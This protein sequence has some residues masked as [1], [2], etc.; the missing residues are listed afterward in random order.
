MKEKILIFDSTLRDGAQGEGISFSVRDKIAVCRALS[1]LGVD[2]I[3][4]GNPASNPK[5]AEFFREIVGED[6]GKTRL[7]A[8][9]STRRKGVRAEDDEGLRALLE[10]NTPVVAV[11]G[12]SWD[13][14][15]TEIIRVGLGENLNMIADTVKYLKD[16]GKQVVF[17]AEH[18]FDGYKHNPDYAI[19]SLVAAAD[20]GADYIAL[21]DTNGGCFPSEIAEMTRAAIA[22][23]DVP[24]MIHAHDDGGMAVANSVT[25]VES[26]ARGVQGTL[27]GFGERCGNANLATIIANLQLKRGYECLTAEKM[28]ELTGTSRKIAEIA[29]VRLPGNAPY[30]GKSAFAHK[31]GMHAD[32]VSKSSVSFEHV[33]PEAVGNSRRFLTSE[34]AGRGAILEK[35]RKIDASV[36]KDNP[37]TAD[38][39]NKIKEMEY[40]GY[41]FEGAEASFEL[42]VLKLLGAYK[43][44]FAL[45]KFK[46]IG[47]QATGK[48][49][50]PATAVVKVRVGDETEIRAAEGNGPVNA[51]DVALRA[52]LE[53]F[54][55]ELGGFSLTDYKVRIIDSRETSSAKTRVLIE[56][57][58]GRDVW[59]TVG[60][61]RDIIEAS[62]IALRDAIEYKLAKDRGVIAP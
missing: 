29:N 61:S 48:D 8:F 59:T 38:I 40:L 58:D 60:V 46:T 6:F 36:T 35:V 50:S 7:T 18:F 24:V 52:A 44:Y 27:N 21:C 1:E 23:V 19:K 17:D 49:F 4:A 39:V 25:A 13:F 12:K 28:S 54:Y 31:A 20:S 62:L 5:D 33:S 16:K 41:Q 3:E 47:E 22:A 37:V 51:L 15:A 9:G 56:S 32:G 42:L 14:H 11:F 55:P 57:G 43:P 2:F 34:V 45:E 26:G 53:R 10:A 30:V